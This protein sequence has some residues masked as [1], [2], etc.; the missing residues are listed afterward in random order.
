MTSGMRNSFQVHMKT[1]TVSVTMAGRASGTRTLHRMRRVEAPSSRAASTS[2]RLLVR[3]YARIQNVPN[4]TDCA[5]CGR[6]TAQSVSVSPSVAQVEVQRHDDRL[7]RHHDA[8]EEGVE[9]HRGAA[10]AHRARAR[11]R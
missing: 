4:A 2:E 10:E 11:T 7:A 6:T 3:K 9:E 8:D 1:S 5:I